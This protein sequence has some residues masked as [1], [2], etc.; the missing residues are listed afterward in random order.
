MVDSKLTGNIYVLLTAICLSFST[1]FTHSVVQNVNPIVFAFYS[2][3]LVMVLLLLLRIS[4]FGGLGHLFF[5]I[6]TSYKNLIYINVTSAIDWILFLIALKY[7]NGSFVNAIVFGIT[8]IATL[9]FSRSFTKLR[10]LFSGIIL[11]LLM[12]VGFDYISVEKIHST[13]FGLAITFCVLAGMAVGGTILFS[14]YLSN[15]QVKVID[16]ILL[17]YMATIIVSASI[18]AITQYSLNISLANLAKIAVASLLFVLIPAYFLQKGIALISS[19]N[20]A[21]ISSSIPAITYFMGAL[22]SLRVDGVQMITIDAL[23][24]VLILYSR[25]RTEGENRFEKE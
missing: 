14:K 23:S 24:L 1:V 12:V 13:H 18:I 16:V 15:E 7:I 22:W 6:K 5:T 20:A 19:F 17:R 2:F 10:C 3:V 8:P 9:L 25:L 11:I 4:Y 21:V